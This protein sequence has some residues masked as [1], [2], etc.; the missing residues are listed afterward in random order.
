MQD[1]LEPVQQYVKPMEPLLLS[2]V[3]NVYWANTTIKQIKHCVKM[4]AVLDPTL[5]KIK[6]AAIYVR[7]ER[8]KTMT[9]N[10]LV[11]NALLEKY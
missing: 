1:I 9:T 10:H 3:S 2:N 11:R 8:G 7:T 4:I 5:W 6:V